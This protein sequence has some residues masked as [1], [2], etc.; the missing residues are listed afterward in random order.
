MKHDGNI[1]R[2]AFL[3]TTAVASAASAVTQGLAAV[4]QPDSS[5]AT[6]GRQEGH[7]LILESIAAN[8]V[9]KIFYCGGTD[10]FYFMESVAK[11]KA[12]GKPCPDLVTVMH[13]SDAVY[14]NMGYAQ[15]SGKP[16]VTFLHVDSGTINAGA[17][18]S[19]AWHANAGIVVMAG[20]TPWTSKNE[21]PG[22]RSFPVHWEQEVYDQAAIVRQYT[23]WD[24]EIKTVE[25][26]T[27]VIQRA[28]R[29][30]AS[31]PCGPAYLTLPREVVAAQ[32]E[33]ERAV[34]YRP[35][36][37][38]PAV[39]AQGDAAALREA[40]KKLVESRNPLI[41]VKSMG[42]HPEAV[43]TLVALAE[44]L[45][46]AVNST[47]T[48]V[49]F[50]KNHWAR[51]E[52]ELKDRDVIFIIDHD[53]PW[54]REVPSPQATVISMDADPMRMK[55]P[56]WGYPVHIPIT[57][58]S[59]KALPLLLDMTEEFLTT[60]RRGVIEERRKSL[61]SAR[62]IADEATRRE[63][64]AARTAYPLSPVW[65]RECVNQISDED[66]VL[67]WE[68][69]AIRQG[70]RTPP[71][72]VF[73]QYA[74]NLGNA[75]PRGIGIKMAAPDKTVIASGGDG[76]T[77][78][79]NPEAAL[80]TAR[81]YNAPILYIVNNNNKYA[82][83]EE[84][85]GAYGGAA[86]YAGKAGFNGSDL[87]PSPDFAMIAKAMGAYGEKVTEPDKLPAALRRCLEA[88]KGGQSAVLDTVIVKEK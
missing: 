2:R 71:G 36:D 34:R 76:A 66:T 47:D 81:K 6:A 70:D 15:W 79:S 53:V 13:E 60:R 31:E 44:K 64:E 54:V 63:I 82:A 10:N 29:V 72:H 24:Y 20:R 18:W 39:S 5:A 45:A 3:K 59:S 11:F 46:I 84:G 77:I 57:C 67:L 22:A 25:N 88:V 30:A 4:A 26:A 33:R 28:F 42:R 43:A 85:L 1:G 69:A 74:A 56:L 80:W 32:F 8:G 61:Q 37:F 35:E 38:M 48:F 19:E 21:L 73:S 55:Q 14:M 27:L 16:Q 52:A 86:S 40:A 9:K 62:K 78:F 12:L 68:I 7:E 17:A 41:L 58:D 51:A 50:P 49:N 87:S 75:W 83:V 65:V 23:K